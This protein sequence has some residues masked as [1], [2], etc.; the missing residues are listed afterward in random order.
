M[1]AC[2]VVVRI[3]WHMLGSHWCSSSASAAFVVGAAASQAGHTV[4]YSRPI[5]PMVSGVDFYHVSWVIMIVYT[6]ASTSVTIQ[7]PAR[8]RVARKGC[9][10][11]AC[12][13]PAPYRALVQ[14]SNM[15]FNRQ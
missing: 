7:A 1:L 2:G 4:G 14:H 15:V 3:F 5:V 8:V 6:S 13:A 12:R 10:R 11:A 9:S